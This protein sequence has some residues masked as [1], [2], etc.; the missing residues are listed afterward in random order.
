[1]VTSDTTTHN[2]SLYIKKNCI[3][4]QEPQGSV[5]TESSDGIIRMG[6]TGERREAKG[7][8]TEALCMGLIDR[9][10]FKTAVT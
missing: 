10:A 4:Q 8:R 2:T 3:S 6:R 7:Q 5:A 1:V 9:C